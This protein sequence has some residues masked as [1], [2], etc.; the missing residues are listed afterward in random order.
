MHRFIRKY[1]QSGRV[2]KERGEN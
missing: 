2:V 1:D